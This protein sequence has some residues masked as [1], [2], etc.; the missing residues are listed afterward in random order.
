MGLQVTARYASAFI[1]P[2]YGTT[3]E[4]LAGAAENQATFLNAAV[5]KPLT[6]SYANPILEWEFVPSSGDQWTIAPD[7]SAADYHFYWKRTRRSGIRLRVVRPCLQTGLNEQIGVIM[8][9]DLTQLEALR[10][11]V[12]EIGR[13]PI[14]QTSRPDYLPILRDYVDADQLALAVG[15]QPFPITV[16]GYLL[17][18]LS[19]DDKY[20]AD[21]LFAEPTSYMPL[22]RMVAARYQPNSLPSCKI[23]VPSM[24]PFVPILPTRTMTVRWGDQQN[25]WEMRVDAPVMPSTPN[26]FEVS[27]Y[28]P[29][30]SGTD[31]SMFVPIPSIPTTVL[32]PGQFTDMQVNPA[33]PYPMYVRVDEFEAHPTD[34]GLQK[35]LVYSDGMMLVDP[36]LLQGISAGG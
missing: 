24:T 26:T 17:Q 21:I 16:F 3:T 27:V 33:L 35:R 9:A 36:K 28:N 6:T 25:R 15:G 11:H 18:Y 30:A 20:Y 31:P 22:V 5:P 34:A 8:C 23:S 7:N 14:W 29:L 1:N 4:T 2:P 19:S 12:T 13:N 32:T 10:G